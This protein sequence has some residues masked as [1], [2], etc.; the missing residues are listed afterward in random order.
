VEWVLTIATAA[1]LALLFA[2]T[3]I[4]RRHGLPAETTRRGAHVL[5]AGAVAAFP[6]Y[7]RLRDG[8]LLAAAA[9]TF[10]TYTWVR[11][12]LPSIHAVGR[13]S[14]GAPLF[15]I[16]FAVAALVVWG[17]PIAFAFAALVLALADPAA[18]IAGERIGSPAW[19]VAGGRKSLSGSAAFFTVSLALGMVAGVASGDPRPP[20]AVVVAGILTLIEGSLGYGLDNLPLPVVTAVLGETLLGL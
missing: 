19:R 9:G 13:P 5:G 18:A 17:H 7:L 14:A 1:A 10:L 6:L 11:S 15:P 8:L 20:A 4:A 16:G 2:A 3:E 12:R